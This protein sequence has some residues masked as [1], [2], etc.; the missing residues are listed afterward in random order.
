MINKNSKLL[1][2]LLYRILKII[3]VIIFFLLFF[4][5]I[6]VFKYLLINGIFLFYIINGF[7]AGNFVRMVQ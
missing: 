1:N 7:V 6:R 2:S 5:F 4:Y 3:R